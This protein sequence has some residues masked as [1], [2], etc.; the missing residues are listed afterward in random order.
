M[1]DEIP[2]NTAF[3]GQMG[4]NVGVPQNG[5]VS[6]SSG[7]I[8][9]GPILSSSMFR[10]ADFTAPGYQVARI[11]VQPVPEPATMILLGTGLVGV[12]GAA[13]RRRKV[14]GREDV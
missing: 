1:S 13:Y 10:N 9:G 12:A 7:Y 14:G 6:L 8:P 4:E 11:T 5:V 3:F 2:M